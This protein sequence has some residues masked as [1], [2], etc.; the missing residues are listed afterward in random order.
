MPDRSANKQADGQAE[1]APARPASI[2]QQISVAHRAL[3]GAGHQLGIG[4]ERLAHLAGARR[5]GLPAPGILLGAAA[6]QFVVAHIHPHQAVGNIDDDA[7][8]RA[9]QA[10]G[11]ALGRFGRYMADGQPRRSAR[12]AAVG[13]EGTDLAQALRFEIA[14]RVEH[15]LHAG[16][17]ARAFIADD[18]HIA[19]LHLPAQNCLDRRV[20]AFQHHG[21]AGEGEDALVHPGGLDDAAAFG[22]IAEQHG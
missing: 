11:A 6:G 10:D 2:V 1:Q 20:L 7:V 21:G 22:Q 15:F 3:V 12:E 8:A 4:L 19:R 13:D 17:A 18:D 5:R 16:A 9:H 14:R